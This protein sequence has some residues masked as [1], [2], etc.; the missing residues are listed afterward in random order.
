MASV[1]PVADLR[2]PLPYEAVA[3]LCRRYDV[4]ELA[5]FGSALTDEF[6]RRVGLALRDAVERSENYIRRRQI[7]STARVI[8][9]A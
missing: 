7:L 4:E 6:D 9:V 1:T 8:Y 3:A 2:I 5:V